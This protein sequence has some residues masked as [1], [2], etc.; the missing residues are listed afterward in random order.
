[1]SRT[2]RLEARVGDLEAVVDDAGVDRFALMA[3]SQ[4]GPVVIDYAVRHP[5]RITRLLFYGSHASAFVRSDAPSS[6]RWLPRSS[7]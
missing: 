5:E 1:M 4:G 3:M 6:W 7:R 2:T